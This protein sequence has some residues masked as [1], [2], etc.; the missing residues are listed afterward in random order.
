MTQQKLQCKRLT[1]ELKALEV[2]AYEEYGFEVAQF[3]AF[4]FFLVHLVGISKTSVRIKVY[5][6]K[7][8]Y[9]CQFLNIQDLIEQLGLSQTYVQFRSEF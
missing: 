6:F 4:N 2:L 3:C 5:V 1:E 7:I 9:N 8:S